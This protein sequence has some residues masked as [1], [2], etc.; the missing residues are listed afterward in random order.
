[1]QFFTGQITW[2]FYTSEM[3]SEGF[4][5]SFPSPGLLEHHWND[6]HALLPPLVASLSLRLW[7]AFAHCSSCSPEPRRSPNPSR[8]PGAAHPPAATPDAPPGCRR[9]SSRSLG[10]ASWSAQ[11]ARTSGRK[12]EAPG[13]RAADGERGEGGG[14]ATTFLFS[15]GER[16]K[17]FDFERIY[18]TFR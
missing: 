11:R 18:D 4:Y 1:M 15:F 2:K 14:C 12:I 7:G 6:E 5:P 17:Y 10:E 9:T 8:I 3:G 13:R 16:S